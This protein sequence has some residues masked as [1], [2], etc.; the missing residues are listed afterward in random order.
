M[1][2]GNSGIDF[3]LLWN[4]IYDKELYRNVRMR[5][6]GKFFWTNAG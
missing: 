1:I 2:S 4:K 5:I 6:S 3:Q